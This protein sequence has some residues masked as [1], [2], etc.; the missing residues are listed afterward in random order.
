MH[1]F[2]VLTLA[3]ATA[4]AAPAAAQSD[5]EFV[6]FE[7]SEYFVVNQDQCYAAYIVIDWWRGAGGGMVDNASRTWPSFANADFGSRIARTKPA[8]LAQES[9][10]WGVDNKYEV[11][12]LTELTLYNFTNGVIHIIENQDVDEFV[13]LLE[14]VGNCD[15]EFNFVPTLIDQINATP[16]D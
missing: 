15:T 1:M 14:F 12:L 6:G 4:L 13:A 16:T 5:S 2:K 3:V 11:D 7:N 10:P 8:R 9:E